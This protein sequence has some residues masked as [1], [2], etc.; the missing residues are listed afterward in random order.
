[1][2][3]K[4]C[5]RLIKKK[6]NSLIIDVQGISYEVFVPLTVMQRI[7]GAVDEQGRI[8]L[9]T[10]YY[11]QLTPSNGFPVLIGFLNDLERDFFQDFIKVSGIGPRAA[12]KA[13]NKPISEI[14]AAIDQG[15]AAFLKSLPGIGSQKAKE[16]IAKLQGKVGRYGLLQD[17]ENKRV[18]EKMTIPDWQEEALNLLM[19]L[20]YKKPEAMQMI[21]AALKRVEDI[22]NTEDLLNEIYRQRIAR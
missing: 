22:Q 1:M 18:V 17:Q 9:V 10:Y 7:D 11:F 14:S 5:G 16:V 19:Q 13:I 21:Q 6:E 2:I 20:E 15:D 12:V 4:I 8:E 3:A